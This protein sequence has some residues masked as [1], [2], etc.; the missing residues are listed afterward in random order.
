MSTVA[1]AGI[2][3]DER[4]STVALDRR[5]AACCARGHTCA[6][7]RR[8]AARRVAGPFLRPKKKDS[9]TKAQRHKGKKKHETADERGYEFLLSKRGFRRGAAQGKSSHVIFVSQVLIRAFVPLWLERFFRIIRGL[10]A[11]ERHDQW[12]PA[13]AGMTEGCGN[14]RRMRGDD[15]QGSYRA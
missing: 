10:W 9:T 14:D 7:D 4:M 13:F 2:C 3:R 1:L 12:I 5:G 11:G 8:G 15:K 6:L